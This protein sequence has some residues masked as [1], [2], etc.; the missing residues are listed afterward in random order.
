MQSMQELAFEAAYILM[1][2][3]QQEE[4]ENGTQIKTQGFGLQQGKS[5]IL[6]GNFK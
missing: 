1:R 6:M 4:T 2:K 5:K 3:I